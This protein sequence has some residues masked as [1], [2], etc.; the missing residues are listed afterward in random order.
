MRRKSRF[1]FL[2]LDERGESNCGTRKGFSSG[3]GAV[4]GV[5]PSR[6]RLRPRKARWREGDEGWCRVHTSRKAVFKN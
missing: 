3:G 4:P 5:S 6:V 2:S 1:E